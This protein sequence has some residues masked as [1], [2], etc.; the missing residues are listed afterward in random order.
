VSSTSQEHQAWTAAGSDVAA[1]NTYASIKKALED[2]ERR[3]DL[4]IFLQGSYANTTNIRA[5]SDVDVVV[6]TRQT[7]QGSADRLTGSARAAFDA[8]P[9]ATFSATDLRQEVLVALMAYYGATRVHPRNKCIKVDRRDGY[10]DADVVPCLQYRW[11]PQNSTSSYVEGIALHPAG[12]GR[13]VNF[14][15]RHIENGQQKNAACSG[16]YKKTVRQVKRLRNRAIAEGRLSHG[17]APGYLLECMVYNVPSAQ[18]VSDDSARL[19]KIVLWLKY[20]DK[21]PFMSCDGIHEL[22]R[23]DPGMF[24]IPTAQSII[25]AL[26]DAY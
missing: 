21:S 9:M 25:D 2:L 10:V 11:Y 13:I 26:W 7:F 23:T 24:R 6:M 20:A 16:N 19:S 4:D 8:L 5:D 18:F 3:R 22:F 17:V 12:G 15:K 14:P 1:K